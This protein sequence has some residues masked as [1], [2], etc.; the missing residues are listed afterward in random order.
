MRHTVTLYVQCLS[1]ISCLCCC[2]VIETSTSK[3]KVTK[4]SVIQADTDWTGCSGTCLSSVV[5]FKKQYGQADFLE[6]TAAYV[7]SLLAHLAPCGALHVEGFPS[8]TLRN[9]GESTD[10]DQDCPLLQT[11][12][13]L[14]NVDTQTFHTRRQIT[15][16]Q[17]R[18]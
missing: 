9:H 14:Q 3:L 6:T 1:C 11:Y 13:Q 8:I 18:L 12:S 16:R 4:R 2:Y 7:P 15:Q 10:L 5:Q 17:F